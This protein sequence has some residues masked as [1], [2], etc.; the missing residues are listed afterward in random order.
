MSPPPPREHCAGGFWFGSSLPCDLGQVPALS[1][2]WCPHPNKE[3]EGRV[4]RQ[5]VS[6]LPQFHPTEAMLGKESRSR[7]LALLPCSEA[8]C[9]QGVLRAG[10]RGLN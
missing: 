10:R 8:C 3:V 2:H 1:R 6:G 9:L 7:S 4:Q 5:L